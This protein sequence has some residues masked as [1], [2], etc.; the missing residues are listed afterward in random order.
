MNYQALQFGYDHVVTHNNTRVF[1]GAALNY[2]DM[3]TDFA[4]GDGEGYTV[5]L[6]GYGLA[7]RFLP[8]L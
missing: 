7:V 5:A 4:R 6:T 1:I 8:V 2:T 3:Q